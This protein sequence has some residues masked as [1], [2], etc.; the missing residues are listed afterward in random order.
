L[1]HEQGMWRVARGYV[2]LFLAHQDGP[3]THLLRIPAGGAIP[4]LGPAVSEERYVIAVMGRDAEIDG[5]AAQALSANEMELWVDALTR[6]VAPPARPPRTD[7]LVAGQ[8]TAM[9][10]M[11]VSSK[12][13]T[14][15]VQALHGKAFF[16]GSRDLPPILP[17]V[18]FPLA[19]SGWIQPAEA[20]QFESED[21]GQTAHEKRSLDGFHRMVQLLWNRAAE[22]R[23]QRDHARALRQAGSDSLRMQEALGHLAAPLT[24]GGR[25]ISEGTDLPWLA[26]CHRI[27]AAS[28]IQ[29]VAPRAT[30][31]FALDEIVPA[32]SRASGGRVRRVLLA[33]GWWKKEHEPLLAERTEDR[34][35]VSLLFERGRSWIF[36]PVA[37]TESLSTAEAAAAL[38]PFAFAF[39]RPFPEGPVHIG[40][41]LKFAVRGLKREVRGIVVTS[42][43]AAAMAM[44]LPVV[45]GYVFDRVLPPS[46]RSQLNLIAVLLVL[47]A[48]GTALFNWARGALLLRMEGRMDKV[49]QAA[50]WSRLLDL[51]PSFF[52]RFS[53]GELATRGLGI[54]A[55][56]EVLTGTVI[57]SLLSGIFSL[58][59]LGV[60]FFYSVRLAML[61]T[62]LTAIAFAVVT[63][64]GHFIVRHQRNLAAVQGR[65]SGLALQMI[66]GISKIRVAAAEPRA[67][68]T[69]AREYARQTE[70]QL[71]SRRL[72][73]WVLTFDAVWLPLCTAIIF[74]V[75][76]KSLAATPASADTMTTGDFV[77]FLSAFSVMLRGCL[78]FSAAL[79]GVLSV[80]PTYDRARPI[81]ETTPEAGARRSAPGTLYGEIRVDRVSLRYVSDG[82]LAVNNVSLSIRPGEFVA[83]VGGSGSGKSSLLRLLL[84]FEEPES[85]SIFFDGKDLA[86][87]DPQLVRKQIGV[88]LQGG[89][90]AAGSLLD[91]ITGSLEAT[92]EEAWE[93]ARM[94]GFEEDV[95]N[96]PMGMQ[97]VLGEGGGTLSG[98]QRQRLL[99]ARALLKKPRILFFDEATSALDNHTQAMVSRSLE[100]LNATRVVIAHR[101]STIERA[102]RIYVIDRGRLVQQGTF[103]ELSA[104]EGPF[105]DL[106]RRQ[107]V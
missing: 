3:R 97:T 44:V 45:T 62:L 90:I 73:N 56:R 50:V 43:A 38:E 48:I 61:A 60:L 84:G 71:R 76:L 68:L 2:D 23:D 86:H 102:D 81:L 59:S 58:V 39:Y 88:V 53:A 52:R 93:A 80:A 69:W 96:M 65:L 51:P 70:E 55:M 99:I 95:K 14:L 26:C 107:I 19:A 36:D 91:N 6:T 25:P 74:A 92:A 28:G 64:C 16:L 35:P 32:I 9:D 29:F 41:L 18:W 5:D 66:Y 85:G 7:M 13:G 63:A 103:Q 101:L 37:G 57:T 22:E 42:F 105:A 20:M 4:G 100:Q 67:Y 75:Y 10:S 47:I 78:G 79:I 87:L 49:V 24:R 82:P 31:S 106:A 40:G 94:A 27:G 8:T 104:A 54:Q 46:H 30:D 21:L 98:G 11:P 89:R 33:E 1:L 83:F 12:S 34:S 17:G 72:G 77:G 15:W